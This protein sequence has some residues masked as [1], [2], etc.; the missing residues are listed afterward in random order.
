MLKQFGVITDFKFHFVRMKCDGKFGKPISGNFSR[1]HKRI[2]MDFVIDIAAL[3]V[4]I[5][6][7]IL[8]FTRVCEF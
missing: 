5:K 3:I 2:V 7:E 8:H 1:F 4:S 6:A